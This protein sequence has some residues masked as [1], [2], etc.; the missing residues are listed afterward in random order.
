MLYIIYQEYNI[1]NELI[2]TLRI[3]YPDIR[4]VNMPNW[5]SHLSIIKRALSKFFKIFNSTLGYNI[6]I[7]KKINESLKEIQHNDQILFWDYILCASDI[8]YIINLTKIPVSS[9]HIWLWNTMDYYD[10]RTINQLIKY[11]IPIY[12]F[13]PK[14]AN[15]YNISLLN[16]TCC[17]KNL[18][19]EKIDFDFF[20]IGIDKGR[21]KILNKL[22]NILIAKGYKCNF[23]IYNDKNN[24]SELFEYLEYI[25]EPLSYEKMLE[26]LM[27]SKIVVD[28]TKSTQTGMTLRVLEAI[29]YK[30]KLITNNQFII[31]TDI[32]N[33]E[34]ILIMDDDFNFVDKITQFINTPFIPY[35]ANIIEKYY[36]ENWISKFLKK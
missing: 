16:Q 8:N 24:E 1:T 28:L 27:K 2:N 31:H 23:I 4:M 33:P 19:S 25:N 34:N 10:F 21:C 3:H 15:K 12:T 29:F 32:Y 18:K 30:K 36:I 7:P 26:L 13:D 35:D 6:I 22:A 9:I 11:K 5:Y 20:F 14:D 17:K